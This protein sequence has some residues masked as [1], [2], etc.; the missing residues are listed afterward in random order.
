MEVITEQIGDVCLALI[1]SESLVA[2]NT[3]DFKREISP[4][5]E[6]NA[7]IVLDMS[8]LQFVDSSGIGAIL[9]CMK[10]LSVSGGELKLCSVTKQVRSIFEMV[11]LHWVVDM[12]NTKEEALRSFSE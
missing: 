4:L 6:S 9:S 11:R 1:S 3:K 5:L 10:H 8:Q 12:F 7:K 2:D